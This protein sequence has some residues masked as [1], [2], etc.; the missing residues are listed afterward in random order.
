[1]RLV[2]YASSNADFTYTGTA[3]IV[4]VIIVTVGHAGLGMCIA[5]IPHSGC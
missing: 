5:C 3:M 2:G 4:I 1:M